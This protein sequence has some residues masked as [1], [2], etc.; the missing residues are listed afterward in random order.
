MINLEWICLQPEKLAIDHNAVSAEDGWEFWYITSTNFVAAM[1]WGD[2][3]IEKLNILTAYLIASIYKLIS[4]ETTFDGTITTLRTLFVKP[5]Q[6]IYAR[7]KL[8]TARH[9]DSESVDE[10]YCA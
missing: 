8:A 7:H 5:K 4:E 1:P 3:A 6:E 10:L 2:N 9:N